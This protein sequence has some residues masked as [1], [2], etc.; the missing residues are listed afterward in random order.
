MYFLGDNRLDDVESAELGSLALQPHPLD[1]KQDQADRD[2]VSSVATGIQPPWVKMNA[3]VD[4]M[5]V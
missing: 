2:W 3:E 5:C 1:W 4:A